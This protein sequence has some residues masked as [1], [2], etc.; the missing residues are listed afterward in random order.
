MACTCRT[1]SLLPISGKVLIWRVGVHEV[2]AVRNARN[3][4]QAL[5]EVCCLFREE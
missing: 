5:A 3:G 4:L 1:C 2:L